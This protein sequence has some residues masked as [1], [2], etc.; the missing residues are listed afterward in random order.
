MNVFTDSPAIARARVVEREYE[1]TAVFVPLYC[2]PRIQTRGVV[3]LLDR[4]GEFW[5]QHSAR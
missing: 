4:R 1:V 5:L 2:D 3:E